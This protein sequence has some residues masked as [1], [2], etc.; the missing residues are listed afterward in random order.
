MRGK[1]KQRVSLILV[2]TMVLGTVLTG[3]TVFA[4]G[5]SSDEQDR[6]KINISKDSEQTVEQNVTQTIHVTAQ[7]QCSQSVCLNVYLKNEDGSAATDIDAVNLLTSDQLTDK[8]TQKTINETLKDSVTLNNGTKASPTAEWKNDKDDN[9][10]VTSKYLQITMPTDTTAI[11]FDMQLQ[12]RTDEA[13]Y[14]K[15]VLV[16]A[17]AFEEEQDIT[18]AAK[19][20]DE[21]K[22]NEA[23]VVW[24]GQA[25]SQS[26]SEAADEDADGENGSQV[27]AASADTGVTIYFAAPKEWTEN[28][29]TIKLNGKLNE[30][31]WTNPSVE[32]QDTGKEYN[33]KK[34][35][36]AETTTPNGGYYILQFQAYA[37]S[38]WIKEIL[39]INKWTPTSDI[40]NHIYEDGQ[41]WKDDFTPFDPND[42]TYFAG[43]NILFYNKGAEDLSGGV[44]AVFYE[45]DSSENLTEV[46]RIEMTA[47]TGNKKFSVTIPDKA[48][49]YIRFVRTSNG[50]TLGD[51]Y[52]NFYGQGETEVTK[53]FLYSDSMY[54]YNYN[55]TAD[56]SS[57]G[58]AG[59]V[60]VY[61]DATLS[62][63]SYKD[64][65]GA[66]ND[67]KGIP[68]PKKTD[69]YYYATN[70]TGEI[71]GK[72]TA[73][74]NANYPDVYKADLLDGY[75]QVRFAAYEVKDKN[76]S[77]NGDATDLVTIPGGL[78]NP[79]YY[80]D[81]SDDVIYK[82]GN[83]G[84]Y[85]DE[86]YTVRDPEKEAE[87]HNSKDVVDIKESKLTR[88]A[89]TLYVNSTFYDYYTDYELNG[90]N[91][92]DYDDYQAASQRTYVT[93]RQFNQALSDYYKNATVAIPIY[94]GHFQPNYSNWG[95]P[96]SAIA[97]TLSLYGYDKENQNGFMSTNN[98]TLNANGDGN[99]KYYDAA[100]QGLVANAL[101][102]NNL[103]TSNN[104]VLE[105]HFNEKFLTEDN[106][107]HTALAKIYKNVS[108]P[109]TK[110]KVDEY[111]NKND[112]SGVE[113]WYFDSADTTLAMRTDKESGNYYLEDVD[114]ED[115]DNKDWSK[116][117]NSSSK[118]DN[119]SNTYGFFPFNE[120]AKA[121]S[122]SNYNY[123][124]G[125]K[126]EFKF[127]LTDDGN[128]VGTDGKEYPIK[129]NFSGDDDVWVY[130]DGNL[131]LDVGGAH[132]KV[133]GHIDFSGSDKKK[134]AIVS[135]TKV[136]QGSLIEG[137]NTE[138][139]FEIKGSNSDEHTL[140]M[141]YME[142]GMWES[143]MKVSFNFPD[144]NEFAVEKK[145]D[146]TD[147]NTEL[148][149][150]S[151]FEG[152]SV[153]PFT[154]QNQATHYGTKEAQSS[155]EKQPKTYNDSFSAEKLSKT[156]PQNTF[157][158]TDEK[159]GQTNVV[160][161]KAKSDDAE[162]E[163]INK[164]FGIIRPANGETFDA[165]DTNAFLQFKMYYDYQDIPGL[166]STYLELEDDNEK[167]IGGYLSGKTYGN[168]SLVHNQWNTIQVDLSKLQGD[169]TF[170]YSKIKNIKFNYNFERDIYLDDF[171]FIPSVVAAT[172]TGFVTQQQDIPDYGS[173][174]SGTLK[175][176]K[177]AQYTLSKNDGS[178]KLYR[179]G[180][181]GMFALAD[182]ETATF[183]DQFR[184]GSY[185]AV[186]E[187]VNSSVFDTTWTLYENGQAVSTM[188]EGDTVV[189][190]NLIPSVQNVKSNTIRDGRKEVYKPGSNGNV[191][192]P[193]S[194][195]PSTGYAKN[196]D[197][198]KTENK[199]T[200]VFRSYVAPDNQTT[201]TK[202]KATFVNKV[203]TGEIKICKATA[204]GSDTLS[205]DYTFRV[206]FSNVAELSLESNKIVNEYTIKAGESVTI[207]GIPAGTDYRISEIKSTDGSTLESVFVKNNNT[208]DAGYDPVTKVV[209]GKVI[210]SSDMTGEGIKNPD[211]SSNATIITFNNTLKPTINLN[212]TKEWKNTNN[213]TLPDS[214]KIRL[215]R[216]SDNG[217]NWE[218]VKYDG[219]NETI[220]LSQGYDGNWS[221]SFKDLDQYVNYKAD[222]KVPYIYRVVEVSGADGNETV[223]E[224]NG[225]LNDKYK[226]TYSDNVDCSTISTGISESKTQS[227]TITNTYSP[228]TNIKI[229][230]QDASTK[231]PLNGA[232]FKLEKM[233]KDISTDKLVVDNSFVAKTVTT[234]GGDSGSPL[235][236]AEFEDLTDGTYRLTETKAAKNHSLLKD[237]VIIVINRSDKCL[238]DNEECKVVDN[239]I[240]I[241]ISNQARFN[242]PA[243]G[244]YGR[245][246]VIL[247]G[248]A[249]AGVG[250]FMYR[251]QKRRKE[252]NISQTQQ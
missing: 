104:E 157:E 183:S 49:S 17:K 90:K 218:T 70:G 215:Q 190:E 51:S 86:V 99:D 120:T 46:K 108:F 152:A 113:Y 241:T 96:F 36:K 240:S 122:A 57:W 65:D 12:Y 197:S 191:E 142:R 246:I 193:N 155:D 23:T 206:E 217:Q 67:G 56:N 34:V 48:C 199:N 41:G 82:G 166:T 235:G 230:K 133:T 143:N 125:T 131:A 106:S 209:A 192:I 77:A 118:T 19:R 162:G 140:T 33:G 116:N 242:L 59:A 72:M 50:K 81:S 25:V 176:P 229:T 170:D 97:P 234:S 30:N 132:G 45:K 137:S 136:S 213:I 74:E 212:L 252:G 164:R 233:K 163:H 169:K 62:K 11:N 107:K 158:T 5:E 102:G 52:S 16:E 24:E 134:K 101:N 156:F 175:Y 225:Y 139:N 189:N 43:K 94:T 141:F 27:M 201:M 148:F 159:A 219:T 227:F 146:T 121:C 187:D 61:Y 7:G 204:D 248:I 111:G 98:S 207:K 76:P 244:G 10:R 127:R 186:S 124:F 21:S 208:F 15:K 238:I 3:N 202:L 2:V 29:Y 26:E 60:T 31:L 39:A 95:F 6:I 114:N 103:M 247:G 66:I 151:L 68:Y 228:K 185:I 203:K 69:V 171:I 75:N 220:T 92:D 71:H 47:G 112:T 64:T 236:I 214:I 130:V 44:T 85:W 249:L 35:Y 153:F 161:W 105:P 110:Q 73:S 251:L 177:G 100:A 188:G 211:T 144:E 145:V 109:F 154:I 250:F 232:V 20:A 184:R 167:K 55:G 128:V 14:T 129:F 223:I 53:S 180:S 149:P 87:Q 160:H 40:N 91:R 226:V 126:L 168:S 194:G 32:M 195:Y 115:V 182:G 178:S 216:S 147:V 181:D 79:C 13:S 93:F 231:K 37:G 221:Y 38:K 138:S 8:N 84:G 117:V 150:A 9:G 4:T 222:P 119:V 58:T 237:P 196:Q 88:N 18:E 135:E 172:K 245:Y 198:G 224:G 28:G 63:L 210:A 54:C 165:S 243:T 78:M 89:S 205:G 1:A 239:T 83:R 173:A 42:H 80:G 179:I 174:I 22:E 123:G 200:I